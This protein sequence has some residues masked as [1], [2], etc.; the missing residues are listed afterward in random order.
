M[1]K[2][3]NKPF[4]GTL[5]VILAGVVWSLSGV[6]SKGIDWGGFSKTG[7]RALITVVILGIGRRSFKV[8]LTAGNIIGAIGVAATS[9]LYMFSISLTTSANAIVLQYSMPVFVVLYG[10]LVLHEKPLRRD[11]L[12]VALVLCGVI[13]CCL[14]G[15]KGGRILGDGIAVISGVTYAVVFIAKSR[16]DCTPDEYIFLGNAFAALMLVLL[17]FDSGVHFRATEE[18]SA[19]RVWFEWGSAV[20][21]GLSLGFGYLL[22]SRG[23]SRTSPTV[24][25]IAS[26]V[27]P[28]LNPI[29]VFL[30]IGENPG[31]LS[32]IGSAV[33]LLTVT[34]YSI[35]PALTHKAKYVETD[36]QPE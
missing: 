23:I 31:A 13:L 35:L 16:K 32:L 4:Y 33:V 2:L 18:I 34:L 22:F 24:A 19:S 7:I 10:I 26:N 11:I 12:A 5:L 28:V 3:K 6:L 15:M 21:M 8:R 9:L 30:F 29:W 36:R 25:A 17:P 20:V 14:Q 1:E 27:E